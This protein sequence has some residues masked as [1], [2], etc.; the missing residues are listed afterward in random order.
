MKK[1]ITAELLYL[2]DLRLLQMLKIQV[3]KKQI[4]ITNGQKNLMKEVP[5]K[6]RNGTYSDI[7][8]S[9]RMGSDAD[10]YDGKCDVKGKSNGYV[11]EAGRWFV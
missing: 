11:Y 10:C 3:L 1:I 7:I 2:L 6:L 5:M 8:I 4:V 9:F